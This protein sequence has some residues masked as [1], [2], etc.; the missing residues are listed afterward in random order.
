M[1][2]FTQQ[3]LLPFSSHFVLFKSY[4]YVQEYA[5]K[6]SLSTLRQK[7]FQPAGK[8]ASLSKA[9]RP[10]V[11]WESD[12]NNE[13]SLSLVSNLPVGKE[14]RVLQHYWRE[15]ARRPLTSK[16]NTNSTVLLWRS[17]AGILQSYWDILQK[18]VN[19]ELKVS[20]LHFYKRMFVL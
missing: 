18:C 20:T 5:R 15:L 19:S 2:K 7:R 17:T 12:T 9:G 16:S 14:M 4:P 10:G 1:F 13:T 11:C 3:F 8:S 6:P